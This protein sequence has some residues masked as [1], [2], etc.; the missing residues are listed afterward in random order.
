MTVRFIFII[1][2]EGR[3]HMTQAIALRQILEESGH[4]VIK[5][6]VGRSNRRDVPQFFKEQI[7]T[8]IIQLDSPNFITDRKQKS[9]KP[10]RSLIYSILR[11]PKY[12]RSLNSLS[13]IVDD[14]QPDVLVNFYDFIGGL[15]NFSR[16]PKC[17]FVC[18]AHQYLIKH[19]EFEFPKGR[20]IN[21]TSLKIANKITSLGADRILA[22]SFKR[23]NNLSGKKTF[24][25]PPLLRKEIQEIK[26]KQS[27]F[28]L[29]YLVNP[30]Y[31]EE[32]RKFH[33]L[34][35]KIPIHC[36]WD[37]KDKPNEWIVDNTLIFHQLDG[38]KFL[39]KMAFCKGYATTSGFES[40]CE[41]MYLG[42]PVMMVPVRGHYEQ[43]CNSID[44][45]K[46]GAGIVNK[47]FDLNELL[48]FIPHYKDTSGW[49]KDWVKSNKGVFLQ[50]LTES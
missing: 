22:L 49:F 3:G 38:Q 1:Q 37:M 26:V 21:R 35:P 48:E 46:A 43:S 42:K 16:K 33:E 11:S 50:H 2:G 5:V 41:A 29:V 18:I 10:L 36:F 39:D 28:L 14:N 8:P 4:H 12:Q 20:P 44:A 47:K 27:D 25:V 23:L 13:K 9:V 6:I 15:Y 7:K 30:G 34:N 31:G 17:R 40:V 19:P 32:I 24:I 45:K